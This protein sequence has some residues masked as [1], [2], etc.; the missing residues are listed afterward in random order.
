MVADAHFPLSGGSATKGV[1]WARWTPSCSPTFSDFFFESR[2]G[3]II[4]KQR[5]LA[6]G[7]RVEAEVA[8]DRAVDAPCR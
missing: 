6:V 2:E 1:T 3:T 8:A 7:E 4:D 5:L